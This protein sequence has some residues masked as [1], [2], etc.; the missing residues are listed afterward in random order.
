MNVSVNG[1]SMYV[2]LVSPRDLS[3]VYR[4][5]YGV[6]AGINQLA[7]GWKVPIATTFDDQSR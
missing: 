3:R 7:N 1:L 6:Y 5:S 4:V 2:S